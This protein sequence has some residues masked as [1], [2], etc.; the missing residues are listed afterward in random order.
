MSER[1]GGMSLRVK[2]IGGDSK[3]LAYQGGNDD[4]KKEDV[5]E[6]DRHS[7]VAHCVCHDAREGSHQAENPIG[8]NDLTA[9]VNYLKG[10]NIFFVSWFSNFIFYP[11]GFILYHRWYLDNG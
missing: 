3:T 1:V 10:L 9:I 11:L 2:A 4:Q 7:R 6:N 5:I 8:G